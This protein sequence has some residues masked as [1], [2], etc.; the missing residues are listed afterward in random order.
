MAKQQNVRYGEQLVNA[1][2][3]DV[4]NNPKP[5]RDY[6]ISIEHPEFTC[7]CPRSGYPDF[8]TILIEYV[9]LGLCVELKS[10]KLYI[11]SFRDIYKYHE[12]VVNEICDFFVERVQPKKLRI[13]GDFNRRGNIKT[14]V[15]VEY[16]KPI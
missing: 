6:T 5:G 14:V 9:P 16:S 3:L 2:E 4:F 13:T 12:A 1:A 10:W 8:A 15:T 11:N 7:K